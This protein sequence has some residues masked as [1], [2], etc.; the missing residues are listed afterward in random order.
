MFRKSLFVLFC[1]CIQTFAAEVVVYSSR[2]EQLIKPIFEKFTAET[3]IEVSYRTDKAGAL[4]QRIKAEGERTQADLLLTV[5]AGNLWQ[6]SSMDLL[7]PIKADIVTDKV[8]AALR[9]ADNT[10]FGLSI[11]A[12]TLVYNTNKL[13]PSDLSTYA[14]LAEDDWR[15]K[16]LLRTS[17]K[18]YNQSL[19]AMLIAAYGEEKT[20][21]IVRGWV[22]NLAQPV[23][24]SDTKLL[25][26][27]ASGQGEVGIVNTYY[28]GRLLKKEPN[29]PLKLFWPDQDGLGVHVN[30]SGAGITKHARNVEGATRLVTWMLSET[31]QR[32]LADLN[33]EYPVRDDIEPD[34]AVAAWGTF[35]TSDINLAKA[36]ELQRKAIMLMDRVGYN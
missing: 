22:E 18:V 7:Q 20:E 16:V 1:L 29:L 23:F 17:K 24:S 35:K 8:P 6:A 9:A 21:A 10:W 36:G 34:P 30:I 25:E 26:A 14:A 33:M 27:L 4:I 5:D 31:G 2:N 19:V 3:G 28:Y 32:M 13:D 12:R 15:G 11:R